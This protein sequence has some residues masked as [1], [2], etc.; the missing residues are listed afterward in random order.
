MSY[1]LECMR[2]IHWAMQQVCPRQKATRPS[3]LVNK[4]PWFWIGAEIDNES[5]SITDIVNNAIKY[6]NVV[7]PEFLSEISGYSQPV[8][9][10]YVDALTLE[11]KEFP[12]EG[13]VIENA[14]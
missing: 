9:W 5:V 11:E 7:T 4:L 14:N 3:V 1:L 6:S 2:I 10:K 13:I 12:P 8:N